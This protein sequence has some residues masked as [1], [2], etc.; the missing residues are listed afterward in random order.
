MKK[1]FTTLGC[2][3]I[4][5]SSCNKET[6]KGGGAIISENR[7]VPAFTE[8]QINGDGEATVVYGLTQEVTVTGYENLLPVYE[9][10]MLGSV[11]QLQFKPNNYRIRNNNIK[12]RITVPSLSNLRINGSGNISAANF[13]NGNTLT[14]Y[15][16]GSG[17]IVV[18]DS[19][20][21]NASYI[22]NGSGEITATTTEAKQAA[23]EI[24]GS[25]NIRLKVANKLDANISGSGTIDYW[26]NPTTVNT[27]VSGSGKINKQ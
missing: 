19:K 14:T 18:K 12:V 8:I 5:L 7:T 21:I 9:T 25:G 23:A 26:G 11:L 3:L 2:S 13:A 15:I 4:L 22:I 17:N 1:F 20:Y 24:H 10:K 27:Q 6:I 16:N